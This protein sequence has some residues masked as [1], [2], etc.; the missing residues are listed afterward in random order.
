MPEYPMMVTS[1]DKIVKFESGKRQPND[2]GR[3]VRLN[4]GHFLNGIK[5]CSVSGRM[6]E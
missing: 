6:D 4:Q 2:D 1:F 3:K 5:L